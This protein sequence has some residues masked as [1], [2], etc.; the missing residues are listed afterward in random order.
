MK[1]LGEVTPR[2]VGSNPTPSTERGDGTEQA[3]SPESVGYAALAGT[4]VVSTRNR[5][6]RSTLPSTALASNASFSPSTA[7]APH[8]V[9]SFINVV[10]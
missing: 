10:G 7:V 4:T 9:V 6:V 1:P 5:A 8:R 2:H 3:N